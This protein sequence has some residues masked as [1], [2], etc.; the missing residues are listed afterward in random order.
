RA[1]Q[2]IH[3]SGTDLEVVLEHDRL[4]VEMVVGESRIAVEQLQ[5]VVDQVDEPETELLAGE[6]P[7]AIPVGMRNDVNVHQLPLTAPAVNPATKYRCSSTNAI[8]TGTS[9]MK[10]AAASSCQSVSYAL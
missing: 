7:L 3:L 8:I 6:I 9:A 5:Q 2:P 10:L 4:A 1:L